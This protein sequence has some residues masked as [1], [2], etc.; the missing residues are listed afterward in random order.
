MPDAEHAAE[1]VGRPAAP[2]NLADEGEDAGR[3]PTDDGVMGDA[4]NE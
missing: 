4:P 3:M 2:E 1:I